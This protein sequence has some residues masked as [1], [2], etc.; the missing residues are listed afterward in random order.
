MSKFPDG[1]VLHQTQSEMVGFQTMVRVFMDY[2]TEQVLHDKYSSTM[3][4]Y[5]CKGN[6]YTYKTYYLQRVEEKTLPEK[7]LE[8][9]INTVASVPFPEPVKTNDLLDEDSSD[10][11]ESSSDESTE[12]N[13]SSDS[14]KILS[15][16]ARKL[17]YESEFTKNRL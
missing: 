3:Y 15:P 6:H 14:R 8:S 9:I 1:W 13:E 17:L 5:W 16:R 10:S 7:E 2:G 11:S 4:E 12:S